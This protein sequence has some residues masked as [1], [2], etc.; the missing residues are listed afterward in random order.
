M[1]TSCTPLRSGVKPRNQHLRAPRATGAGPALPRVG[2]LGPPT[3]WKA[4]PAT[5]CPPGWGPRPGIGGWCGV[6]TGATRA[7]HSRAHLGTQVPQHA[8]TPVRPLRVRVCVHLCVRR[9]WCWVP[10][11]ACGSGRRHSR[12]VGNAAGRAV[13][14][15]VSVTQ[16]CW[17]ACGTLTHNP[18][19]QG[20]EPQSGL[21]RRLRHLMMFT[22]WLT[23][24]RMCPVCDVTTRPWSPPATCSNR[25]TFPPPGDI[26][27]V[28][29]GTGTE[30][31]AWFSQR[32][33]GRTGLRAQAAGREG[34]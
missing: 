27:M 13:L 7:T 31:D 32:L 14:W 11:P 24:P 2:F 22:V 25:V 28:S 1:P 30:D 5:L 33:E 16:L 10:P 34:P 20:P 12:H 6:V 23:G 21:C 19:L 3:L 8:R 29:S 18:D 17:S 9:S 15:R 4:L 26:R